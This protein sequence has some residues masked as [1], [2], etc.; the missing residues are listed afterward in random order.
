MYVK[1]VCIYVCIVTFF[2]GEVW[3]I[4]SIATACDNVRSITV[5]NSLV[6]AGLEEI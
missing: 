3:G 4:P 5:A 1:E 2:A 6:Y